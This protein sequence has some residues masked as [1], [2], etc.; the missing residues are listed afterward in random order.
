MIAI[1]GTYTKITTVLAIPNEYNI[2]PFDL[3]GNLL[4]EM[5]IEVDSTLA[6]AFIQLPELAT[7]NNNW[8]IK[9]NVISLTGATFPVSISVQVINDT[10]GSVQEIILA[11][12]GRNAELSPISKINWAANITA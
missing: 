7:L 3:Y 5:T 10:I 2:N 6:P 12:N 9:I 4:T 8:N 1:Q 11:A